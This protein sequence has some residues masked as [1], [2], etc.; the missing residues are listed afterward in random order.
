[1]GELFLAQQ[2]GIAGFAKKLVVKRIKAALA[3]DPQF[4]EMFLDEGRIAALID[5]PNVVQIHELGEIEGRYFIA[6]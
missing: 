6:M 3:D 1:M 4:V 2:H 5:H